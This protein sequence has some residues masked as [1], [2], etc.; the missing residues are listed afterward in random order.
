MRNSFFT[1]VCSA[2][3][4]ACGAPSEK[5]ETS[6]GSSE[7]FKADSAYC[8][9][10]RGKIDQIRKSIPMAPDDVKKLGLPGNFR[11]YEGDSSGFP[12]IS[13]SY[14]N[15]PAY[16][17]T[18]FDKL[19]FVAEAPLTPTDGLAAAERKTVWSPLESSG[20]LFIYF[21]ESVNRTGGLN[22][23]ENIAGK[24]SGVVLVYDL[25]KM[26]PK[27]AVSVEASFDTGKIYDAANAASL[28]KQVTE[29]IRSKL[30]HN[31]VKH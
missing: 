15:S 30:V 13:F 29:E 31:F 12:L 22:S 5:S 7:G 1:L 26:Q 14:F 16:G 18:D 6:V 17:K 4:I 27:A 19:A 21:P 2:V 20:Y 8:A 28:E 11:E 24:T 10:W 23:K 25:E 9:E 3:L